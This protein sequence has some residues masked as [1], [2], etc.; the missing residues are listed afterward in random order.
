MR[1]VQHWRRLS[2]QATATGATSRRSQVQAAECGDEAQ[3]QAR[4]RECSS[5]HRLSAVD[6]EARPS[7]IGAGQQQPARLLP[8]LLPFTPFCSLATTYGIAGLPP[9][10]V[11]IPDFQ[12]RLASI[13]T[14]GTWL[15]IVA[16]ARP[17][18]I[19]AMQQ[20]RTRLRFCGLDLT[21]FLWAG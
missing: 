6:T 5:S 16:E 13:T 1:R 12:R 11:S 3:G 17:L 9:V 2:E 21:G 18:A 15:S 19:V 14:E 7:F 4:V 20:Q 10:K 8:R